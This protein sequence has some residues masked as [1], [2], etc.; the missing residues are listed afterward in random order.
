MTK[1]KRRIRYLCGWIMTLGVMGLLI[2]GCGQKIGQAPPVVVKTMNVSQNAGTHLSTYAGEVRGRYEN[3]LAFRVGGKITNRF[4]DVGTVVHPGDVLMELDLEDLKLGT[5]RLDAQLAAARSDRELAAIN[6]ARY[7]ALHNQG[8]ISQSELDQMQNTYEAA[9]QKERDAL[10]SLSQGSNQLD[11]G[12]LKADQEG[13]ISEI[14]AEAG[15]V[16]AAG[17]SVMTLVRTGELEVEIFVPEQR[18]GEITKNSPV[19]VTF[20][21]LPGVQVPG[22]VREVAPQADKT[23]RTYRVRIGMNPP[24]F[25]KLGMS[26]TIQFNRSE[27]AQVSVPLTAIYQTDD[28]PSV[29][30]V[31]ENVVHRRAVQ[32]GDYGNNSVVVVQGLDGNETIVTAGVQKLVEGQQVR[33]W[34]GG[35]Q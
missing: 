24:P 3:N 21:A 6:L 32:L 5:N 34:D 33:L 30:V 9:N 8:A 25:V 26:A 11:Y 35:S 20:W 16:V 1:G 15:Q 2:A 17:Q 23:T 14:S 7:Q 4:V 12:S 10:A 18:L 19:T 22:Q 27:A 28:T 13:V 31:E 29:W